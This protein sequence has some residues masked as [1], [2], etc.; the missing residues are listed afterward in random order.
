M[1]LTISNISDLAARV[2]V[3]YVSKVLNI[4]KGELFIPPNQSVEVKV[5]IYARKV[6]PDYH[7]QITI[8]NLLNRDNDQA[9]QV[10]STNI[11]EY[12]LSYHSLFY[13]LI[14]S[15]SNY[16]DLGALVLNCPSLKSFTIENISKSRLVL[17]LNTNSPKELMVF[18]KN[19]SSFESRMGARQA[20]IRE[21]L[22]S[23][24]DRKKFSRPASENVNPF[25][26][27]KMSSKTHGIGLIRTR[28]VAD[29]PLDS[30]LGSEYL[31]LASSTKDIRIKV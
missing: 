4:Y 30:P 18:E 15:A 27:S 29:S 23:I 21:L 13:R 14:T 28:S 6:N 25:K 24:S 16:L 3:R 7:K 20:P 5:D 1:P 19:T 11:D 9:V 10:Y 26:S 17:E 12:Q 2:E 8:V 31:D 22:Q